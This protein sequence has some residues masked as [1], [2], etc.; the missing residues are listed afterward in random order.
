MA[1]EMENLV[2]EVVLAFNEA[3][4]A[5]DVEGMMALLTPSSVFENTYPAPDGRRYE[6]L[7][8]VRDFWKEFFKGSADARIEVEEIFAAGKRCTMRWRYHWRDT[9]G[10]EG[11][12]R[13]VDVYTVEDGKIAEKLSY[14]KG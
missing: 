2:T 1:D 11:H 13:G 7:I 3:L 10:K 8:E 5:R 6:G 9:D 4:N 12:I 14:V